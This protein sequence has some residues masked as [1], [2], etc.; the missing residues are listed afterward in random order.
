M[1]RTSYEITFELPYYT[2]TINNSDGQGIA[3][4][5]RYTFLFPKRPGNTCSFFRLNDSFDC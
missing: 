2:I 5:L 3:Y 4:E 1:I